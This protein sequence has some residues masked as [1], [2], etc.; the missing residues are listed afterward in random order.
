M[1]RGSRQPRVHSQKLAVEGQWREWRG[2]RGP[3]Q[4]G[5]K[6]QR[7]FGESSTAAAA[8][9]QGLAAAYAAQGDFAKS[10]STLLDA[11]RMYGTLYGSS[12]YRVTVPLGSLCRVYDQWDKPD[13]SEACHAQMVTMLEAQFGANSPALVRDLD[14][15]AQAL[16]KLGR[17]EQAAKLEGRAQSIQS[18]QS[19]P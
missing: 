8:L 1:N 14:A 6:L 16:R 9:M 11:V 10:E 13:K 7:S 17:A 19:K 18:S 5:S 4:A 3:R 12:D 2:S 15:E